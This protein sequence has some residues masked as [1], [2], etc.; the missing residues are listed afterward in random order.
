MKSPPKSS[1][2]Q[3]FAQRLILACCGIG[4]APWVHAQMIGYEGFEAYAGGVQVETGTNGTS[5]TGLDGGSGW[6]GPYDVQNGIK[7]LVFIDDRTVNPVV[8]QNGAITVNGKAR[9][10]FERHGEW[11]LCDP[12]SA[13]GCLG[14]G[15]NGA[16]QFPFLTREFQPA[17]QSG[18]PASRLRQ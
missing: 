2:R 14:G 12:A 6:G 10:A 18:F 1:R 5:G 15:W 13:R 17:G 8:Y 3:R 7:S 9:A 4:I 11:E 16:F